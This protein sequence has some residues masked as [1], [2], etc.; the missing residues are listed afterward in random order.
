MVVSKARAGFFF[1][2]VDLCGGVEGGNI[3]G[4]MIPSY[5]VGHRSKHGRG[6]RGKASGPSLAIM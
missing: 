3:A 5:F 1:I 2:G 4:R 6:E